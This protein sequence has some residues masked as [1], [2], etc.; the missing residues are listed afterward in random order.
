M[1]L[2]VNKIR[3]NAQQEK[4]S[5][6]KKKY[7]AV[8][9][10]SHFKLPNEKLVQFRDLMFEQGNNIL[11]IK[12]TIA[13]RAFN[14]DKL[15][16]SLKNSNFLI[17]GNDIFSLLKSCENFIKSLKVYPD[18]KISVMAGFLDDGYL[19][20]KE[21]A[22][23]AKI[24]SKESLYSGLIGTILYPIRTIVRV[25]DMHVKNNTSEQSNNDN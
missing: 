12:N 7:S 9:M 14:N 5:S 21:T 1:N 2:S 22:S 15:S 10:I 18:A 4:I 11:F 17:F 23:L 16:E 13:N 3:K 20:N 6:L 24:P 8:I 25:L 19:D